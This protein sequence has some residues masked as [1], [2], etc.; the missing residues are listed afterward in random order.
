MKKSLTE[1]LRKE[2]FEELKN[3]NINVYNVH[4][5]LINNLKNPLIVL[6]F[7]IKNLRHENHYGKEGY[8]IISEYI[9]KQIFDYKY[10]DYLI[11]I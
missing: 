4:D 6:P 8:K 1:K 10:K 2:I 9:Y 5:N 7:K 3:K 11:L